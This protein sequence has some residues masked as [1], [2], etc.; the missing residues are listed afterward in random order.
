MTVYAF[1]TKKAGTY[2]DGRGYPAGTILTCLGRVVVTDDV[3]EAQDWAG[4]TK[5]VVA[6]MSMPARHMTLAQFLTENEEGLRAASGDAR[7]REQIRRER[8][9]RFRTK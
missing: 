7:M 3:E 9:R 6:L 1:A 5:Q 2:P 8:A 4:S